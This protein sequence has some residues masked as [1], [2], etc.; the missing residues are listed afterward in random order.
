MYLNLSLQE[1][2]RQFA[3]LVGPAGKVKKLSLF[4]LGIIVLVLAAGYVT[5]LLWN[6]DSRA[7]AVHTVLVRPHSFMLQVH[8]RGIVRPARVV[9]IT[10]DIFSNQAKLV[11]LREEGKPVTKG[12]IVARFDT[13][14]FVD[15]MEKAEQDLADSEAQL[16]S[17]DK[18][19][20]LQV[21]EN[22]G[23]L[24][25]A[26]R[27]L[28]IARIKADD[29]RHGSGQLDR[30]QLVQ[31]LNQ[32]ERAY[33]IAA[34][35]KEDFDALLAKG[36][37][38]QRERDKSVNALKNAGETVELARHRLKNFDQYEMPRR[39][40]EADLMV[41]AAE[42]EMERVK[43]TS[44]LELKRRQSAVVMK[45]REVVARRKQR[46]KSKENLQNCEIK[47]PI[48]GTLLYVEL[49]RAE[50]RRNA[51]VG[52]AIW[53]GQTFMEIPDT[54]ETV[55]EINVRE[56]DVAKL[57][58]G[59]RTSVELDAFPGRMFSGRVER[60]DTLAKADDGNDH[61]RSYKARIL[62][63]DSAPEIHVGMSADVKI[64][65][66]D[67]KEVLA[68]PSAAIE[69][70]S[71]HTFVRLQ[72]GDNIEQKSVTLGEI[73]PKWAQVVSGLKSGD[74]VVVN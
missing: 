73:G 64:T 47:A 6:M 54:R 5:R 58:P 29:L 53:Y 38:S 17:A 44:E 34:A 3:T 63:D 21:E 26:T 1:V 66:K 60:I 50:K 11:W 62:L 28:E 13:K 67:L 14:P 57:N 8:E 24:E 74:E 20:Q 27:E 51:Q 2:Y 36:H 42:K 7:A 12:Q 19:L 23:K 46:D 4:W 35:E 30:Q 71:G 25:D 15:A 43:R 56:V 70:H 61:F 39:L 55:V 59:M 18:A 31:E 33:Q 32:A 41:D 72:D 22:Q 49:P 48:D 10:S 52:D 9:S 45:Q 16:V 69:Y 40:R 37:V 65:Y 68:I